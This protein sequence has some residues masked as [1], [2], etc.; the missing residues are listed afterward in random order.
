MFGGEVAV[1]NLQ[2]QFTAAPDERTYISH[3]VSRHPFH[4]CRAQYV[5]TEPADMATVYI[6]SSAGGVFANDRLSTQLHVLP[7]AK[8][9]VTSQ[10]STIV[11]RMDKGDACQITN[12]RIERDAYM[13]YLPD[14]II[15]FPNARL[16]SLVSI[17]IDPS[18]TLILAD[19]FLA[20]DPDS[21]NEVFSLLHNEICVQDLND[22][23]LCM[24]RNI[25]SGK[26]FIDNSIGVMG[27][28]RVQGTFVILNSSQESESISAALRESLSA[29]PEVYAG[30]STLPNNIGVW[31]RV[32]SHDVVALRASIDKLWRTSRKLLYGSYPNRRKK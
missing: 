31:A 20:H 22:N 23:L 14:P 5:D 13:E 32:L 4:V 12:I 28:N 1:D 26:T 18:S 24:D 2:L 7:G 29:Q 8:A 17:R 21:G 19:S 30:T 27:A 11:H 9:H 3:Q 16:K 10:A 15:L 6:Q 25:F